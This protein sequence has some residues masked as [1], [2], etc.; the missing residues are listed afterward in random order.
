MI[1]AI[2]R[3]FQGHQVVCEPH[4][5]QAYKPV[6]LEQCHNILIQMYGGGCFAPMAQG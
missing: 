1:I 5:H 6:P 3:C 4:L 2:E